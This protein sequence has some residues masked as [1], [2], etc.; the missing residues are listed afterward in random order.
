[1]GLSE[2]LRMPF[3]SQKQSHNLSTLYAQHSQRYTTEKCVIYLDRLLIFSASL[4]EHL[5]K[6]RGAS[7]DFDMQISKLNL[8]NPIFT[9]GSILFMAR[10]N[11]GKPTKQTQ[12]NKLKKTPNKPKVFLDSLFITV[13]SQKKS[14]KSQ[15]LL[16]NA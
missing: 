12:Q 2:V 11:S 5:E 1:M 9:N 4:Q 14:L 16:P 15:I 3:P 6:L 13:N 7:N 8:I 10:C